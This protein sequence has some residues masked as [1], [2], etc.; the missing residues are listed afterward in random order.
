MLGRHILQGLVIIH[1]TIYELRREKI[2]VLLKIDFEKGYD[3][4]EWNFLQQA[5]V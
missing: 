1:E 3:K 4:V 5:L 2:D